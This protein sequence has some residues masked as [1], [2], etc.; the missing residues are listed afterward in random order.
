[1]EPVIILQVSKFN[2]ADDSYGTIEACGY[3][4]LPPYIKISKVK[5]CVAKKYQTIYAKKVGSCCA[6]T[7]YILPKKLVTKIKNK[8][9]NRKID[10][11]VGLAFC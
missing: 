5:H 6:N 8:G 10:L 1:M 9:S 11:A 2:H 7:G 4:P 3:T